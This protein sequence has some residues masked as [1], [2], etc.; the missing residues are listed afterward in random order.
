[1]RFCVKAEVR[2]WLP[3]TLPALR[4]T[5]RCWLDIAIVRKHQPGSRTKRG[6]DISAVS[7]AIA[8]KIRTCSDSKSCGVPTDQ[9][10]PDG[11][12]R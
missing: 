5:P 6:V 7:C 2:S 3:E 1:M 8:T 12:C 11:K 10:V 9:A 4:Y